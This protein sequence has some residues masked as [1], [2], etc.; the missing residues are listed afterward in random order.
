MPLED[1]M[2]RF[3]IVAIAALIAAPALAD[4]PQDV[5]EQK[6]NIAMLQQQLATTQAS[7]G[8]GADICRVETQLVEAMKKLG[9]IYEV[10]MGQLGMTY[11]NVR[12][13]KSEVT[14]VDLP[15]KTRCG[16]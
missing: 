5:D 12:Q 14:A 6:V 9:G 1:P 2:T 4:C 11:M 10:C 16:A 13:Y 8:S 15:H 7:G 3:L